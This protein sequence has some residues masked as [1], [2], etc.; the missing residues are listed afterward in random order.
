MR[1]SAGRIRRVAAAFA[2]EAGLV[3]GSIDG[4]SP[5]ARLAKYGGG[6]ISEGVETVKG[7]GGLRGARGARGASG[8]TGIRGGWSR[9]GWRGWGQQGAG[10]LRA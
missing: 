2:R 9:R 7:F 8:S 4:T 10:G 1:W 5:R 3:V 6:V